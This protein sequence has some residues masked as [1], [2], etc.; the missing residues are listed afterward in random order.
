MLS[1]KG[2]KGVY[3]QHVEAASM[4]SAT[5]QK[6]DNGEDCYHTSCSFHLTFLIIVALMKVLL[7]G[8]SPGQFNTALH[9]KHVKC[10]IVQSVKAKKHP[11][12]LGFPGMG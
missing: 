6:V 12:G 7:G 8:K 10:T 9:D 5:V 4:V 1:S 3:F 2:V 11:A